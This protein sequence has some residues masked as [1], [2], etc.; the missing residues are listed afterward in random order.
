MRR[1]GHGLNGVVTSVA[2]F[3]AFVDVGCTQDS[4]VH[5]SE[6]SH[7]FVKDPPGQSKS[8]S[9]QSP[10]HQGSSSTVAKWSSIKAASEPPKPEPGDAVVATET[11][12][13]G[14]P[15]KPE[16]ATNGA[17]TGH[18]RDEGT[19]VAKSTAA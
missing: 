2:N 14:Q 9:R 10:R 17:R 12:D 8:A 16:T 3:G 4:L 15:P 7:K 18:R 5:I 11:V 6:L 13:G 1:K 19:H